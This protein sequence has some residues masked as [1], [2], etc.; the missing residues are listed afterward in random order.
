MTAKAVKGDLKAV[1]LVA[2]MKERFGLNQVDPPLT[3]ILVTFV[4]P[5]PENLAA[6]ERE[7]EL[8]DQLDREK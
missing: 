2:D 3:N 8:F 5:D 6:Y 4:D 7:D 1:E